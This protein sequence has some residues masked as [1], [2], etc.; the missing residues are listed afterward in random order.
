MSEARNRAEDTHPDIAISDLRIAG[1][2]DG[3]ETAVELRQ[4]SGVP[5][6]FLTATNDAAARLRATAAEPAGYLVKPVDGDHLVRAVELALTTRSSGPAK[7]HEGG[8]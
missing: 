1:Q 2:H 8:E 4:R 3:I 6:L 5:V 7:R